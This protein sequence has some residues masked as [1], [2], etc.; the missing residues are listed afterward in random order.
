MHTRVTEGSRRERHQQAIIELIDKV[1]MAVESNEYTIEGPLYLFWQQFHVKIIGLFTHHE[2]FEKQLHVHRKKARNHVSRKNEKP[3]S[4]FTKKY[5]LYSHCTKHIYKYH[6][7]HYKNVFK[8]FSGFS[9]FKCMYF[10]TL[11]I[12]RNR[13]T[14]FELFSGLLILITLFFLFNFSLREV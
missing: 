2:K 11:W 14:I 4:C 8:R 6:D 12:D 9:R 3:K 13:M 5:K 1:S 10:S 7:S